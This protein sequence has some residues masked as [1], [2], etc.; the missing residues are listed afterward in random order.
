VREI[1]NTLSEPA[2]EILTTHIGIPGRYVIALVAIMG[3][4][5]FMNMM[6]RVHGVKPIK[7]VDGYLE[8]MKER[9]LKR[10]QDLYKQRRAT[11]QPYLRSEE[12][13]MRIS[14]NR[15]C[16][17]SVQEYGPVQLSVDLMPPKVHTN[18]NTFV[19]W[20]SGDNKNGYISARCVAN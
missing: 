18:V 4:N 17:A 14:Q 7:D 9:S 10:K 16:A 13:R 8:T 5:L 15:K 1:G 20:N 2:G 12:N 6:W 3:N 19:S 11:A